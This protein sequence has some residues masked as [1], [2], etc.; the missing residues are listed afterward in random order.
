MASNDH[1]IG[2]ESGDPDQHREGVVVEIAALQPHHP[3]RH[4]DDARRDAVGPKPVDQAPV[5]SF[6]RKRPMAFAERTKMTS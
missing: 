1:E 4:I 6:H 2:D 3:A 5:A